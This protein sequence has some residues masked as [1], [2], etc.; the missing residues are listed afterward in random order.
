MIIVTLLYLLL[1]FSST[2][3]VESLTCNQLIEVVADHDTATKTFIN[4]YKIPVV[5]KNGK[6]MFHVDMQRRGNTH[7]MILNP[8]RN[9]RFEAHAEITLTYS[10]LSQRVLTSTHSTSSSNLEVILDE[11]T[12]LELRNHKV[13]TIAFQGRKYNYEVVL[14]P[15]QGRVVQDVLTCI[16]Y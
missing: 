3:E 6:M 14:K 1:N 12:Q 2:T 10:N 11:E 9:C 16:Q 4:K 13:F 8:V 5:D 7:K 15:N